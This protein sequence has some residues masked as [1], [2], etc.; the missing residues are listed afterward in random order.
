MEEV[1]GGK[2]VGGVALAK[3]GA[4]EEGACDWYAHHFVRVYGDGVGEVTSLQFVFVGWG[5][6]GGTAPGGVDVQPDV[7]LLADFGEGFDGVVGAEDG[8]AGGGV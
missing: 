2:G 5:E 6:D 1:G 4:E 3:V 8:G 7:V